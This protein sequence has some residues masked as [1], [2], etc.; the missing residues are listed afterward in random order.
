ME[1]EAN[2]FAV[3]LRIGIAK[4]LELMDLEYLEF[5]DRCL[6]SFVGLCAILDPGGSV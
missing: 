6:F 2:A 4:L 3:H 5:P 1:Y